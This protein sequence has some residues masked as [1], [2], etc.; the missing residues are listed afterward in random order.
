MLE[1]ALGA[2]SRFLVDVGGLRE[3]AEDMVRYDAVLRGVVYLYS[4]RG[5]GQRTTG[6]M[7]VSDVGQGVVAR[8]LDFLRDIARCGHVLEN[9][10]WNDAADMAAASGGLRAHVSRESA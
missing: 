8:S 9:V 3:V 2:F 7:K 4:W 10:G 6:C 5:T 1:G